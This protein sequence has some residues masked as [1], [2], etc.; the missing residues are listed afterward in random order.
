MYTLLCFWEKQS[1][2]DK[3]FVRAQIKLPWIRAFQRARV[4]AT[5]DVQKAEFS[6]TLQRNDHLQLNYLQE[7]RF[8]VDRQ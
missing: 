7:Y 1:G 2:F 4:K 3:P 6:S 5:F 8:L